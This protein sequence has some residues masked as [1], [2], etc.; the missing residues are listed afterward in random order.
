[1]PYPAAIHEN[2]SGK[3]TQAAS[4]LN[5]QYQKTLRERTGC[6]LCFPV[7]APPQRIS[8]LKFR[9]RSC[10]ELSMRQKQAPPIRNNLP[11]TGW[12]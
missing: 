9:R 6:S 5:M 4:V 8:C 1:M 2:I 12:K 10:P 7:Q 11:T 3:N